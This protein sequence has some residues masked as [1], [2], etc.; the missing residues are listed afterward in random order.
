MNATAAIAGYKMT[1]GNDAMSRYPYLSGLHTSHWNQFV[2]V[3][4]SPQGVL[5]KL[6]PLSP[7]SWWF[8]VEMRV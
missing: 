3:S 7:V 4:D 5:L 8:F 6:I 1:N 2:D